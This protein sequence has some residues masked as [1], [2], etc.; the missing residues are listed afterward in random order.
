M[1]CGC[2][3]DKAGAARCVP[4]VA[5]LS[6]GDGARIIPYHTVQRAAHQVTNG[7][8]SCYSYTVTVTV[9]VTVTGL[10]LRVMACG[11]WE[12]RTGER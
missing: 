8:W 11:F 7:V 4:V 12:F 10:S 2:L 1:E 5:A 3:T 6:S 9:T